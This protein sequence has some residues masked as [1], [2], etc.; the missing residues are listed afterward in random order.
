VS[1]HVVLG[2]GPVGRSLTEV[3]LE[4]GHQLRVLSR[5]GGPASQAAPEVEPRAVD[6]A[7]PAALTAATRGAAALYNCANPAYHRWAQDW[8][9]VASALLTAAESTGSVLV[10]MG[11]LYAYGPVDGPMTEDLPLASTGTKGRVRAGMWQQALARHDAGAVRAV[12]LRPRTSS[13]PA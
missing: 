12:E 2:K 13:V 10:M 6:A 11:N 1:L 4:H 5:S 8:P 9:P 3:L 7:D